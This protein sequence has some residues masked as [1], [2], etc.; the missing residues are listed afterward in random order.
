MCYNVLVNVIPLHFH[1]HWSLLDGVSSPR[2]IVDFAGSHD[3]PALALTDTNALYGAIEFTSAC[4]EA[5][6]RPIIGAELTIAGGQ[7][8]VLLAQNREGYANLCRLVTRLQ[9]A[10]DREASLA[11]GLSLTD[12]AGHAGGLIALSGG[13]AGPLDAALRGGRAERA[14]EL[15]QQFVELFGRDRFFVELQLIEPDDA[16]KAAALARLAERAGLPTVA[17]YDIRYLSPA[18]APRYRVLTAMRTGRRLKDLP[19]LPDLSFPSSDDMRRRF[20]DFPAALDQAHVVAGLCRLDLPLGELHFPTFELPSGR[21]PRDELWSLALAGAA[22]RYG[23][24]T[25]ALEARLRKEVE[26]V[27]A[28]GYAPYFL[29]VADIVRFAREQQVPVSPRGSASSSVVAYCLGIHDVDPIAHSLYFERFL[30]LERRDP[31]DIDLDLCSRRR[32]EVIEYVYRKFGADHV[33]MVCTYATLRPRLAL[34]E[35][36]KAYGLA[37]KRITE[38]SK[39][40]PWFWSP[41]ERAETEAAQAKLLQ[42]ARDPVERE[43]L[44]MSRALDGTPHHLSIH[45]GGIVISPGPITDLVPLQHATKGLLVTQ[46]DLS[47]VAQLGLVKIDLL[48]ISALTVIADSV[49]SIRKRQ[50]DFTAESIPAEDAAAAQTLSTGQTIGCFQIES[51]GMR[52]TLREMQ[53]RNVDDAIVALALFRPGP[54]KGGLKDAFVR[55]HLERED[56]A[57]L[58][59]SLEPILRESHGVILY[60][61]QVLRI[62]HEIAGFSLGEADLLRRAMSK[63]SE[64]EMARLR[65]QFIAGARVVSGMEAAAAEQVWDL[66][67]AFAGYG[68]PKAHAV[69]YASVA[70]RMAY[71]KTHFPAEFMAAR[72]AVWGGYYSPR[73]YMSE[74]RRLG[75]AIRPPHVNHS[76]E[77]FTLERPRTLWMGLDQV[78]EL[79]RTTIESIGTQRP[80]DSLE[81]FLSRARPQHVEAVNLVKAGALEG[82]GNA[83]AML[84]LLEQT[85]WRGRRD[86]QMGLSFVAPSFE[87]RQPTL[88]ERAAWERD[89]LGMPVS[90]H[91]LQLVAG[92]LSPFSLTRS[93]QVGAHVGREV[94]M[95][96]ARL[97]AHRFA[98]SQ[99]EPMLLADMEDEVGIY[100]VLWSGPALT[101][102]RALLSIREPVLIRGRVRTDRQGCFVIVG[103]DVTRIE[104]ATPA[105]E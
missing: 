94:A 91:P 102:R 25:P 22:Q 79:T 38:L 40:L 42:Q 57:Y 16:A 9:A 48:G 69:G 15:A 64:R 83:K 12:L 24:I 87:A 52:L 58:H 66:M 104:G 1:S 98:G 46:L 2:Q 80:F 76:R 30:S 92:E 61:E 11:R 19:P 82:L 95:G 77:A 29:V 44:E 47:G 70:Y 75:L 45:P 73:V 93:D 49:E 89:V 85:R 35:V 67:A 6:I 41:G 13:H 51:P 105:G 55:R 23:D 97:A 54:L 28:L 8:I 100:Q 60:Q 36:G 59:A 56:A 18:D 5:G 78:R 101:Q 90:A 103:Q 27:D 99:G 72:L 84:A 63:K 34:R 96:G 26:V 4:R 32:D 71:L 33:A 65:E 31:P 17:S 86:A 68:F 14:E 74:A 43:V 21:T 53:A 39:H 50:P 37:E 62:A 7:S 20:R 10:P 81:D 3:L 88:Q